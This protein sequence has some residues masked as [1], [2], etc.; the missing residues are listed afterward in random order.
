VLTS[1]DNTIRNID[2]KTVLTNNPENEI[3]FYIGKLTSFRYVCNL[4]KDRVENA[5]FG[6][7]TY[8]LMNAKKNFADVELYQ[9]ITFGDINTNAEEITQ[10]TRQA[11]EFYKA[12]QM[13]SLYTK[14]ILLYYCYLRLGRILFL[15]TY[16]RNFSKLR[17]SSTHGL[18]MDND[19]RC[20]KV[21]AFPRFHDSYDTQP[22]IYQNECRFDWR[23]LLEHPTDRF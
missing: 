16:K 17:G 18:T 19:I 12:S 6:F 15:A 9:E 7:D 14:P 22:S 5:F 11:I 4:L 3:W 1:S 2:N 20:M 13:V 21:G 10:T 23:N 8:S